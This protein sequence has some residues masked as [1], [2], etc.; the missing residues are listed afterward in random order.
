MEQNQNQCGRNVQEESSN[1]CAGHE[2]LDRSERILAA[3]GELVDFST[4]KLT[5]I[6]TPSEPQATQGS[7]PMAE[8]P[9]YFQEL[10]LNLCGVMSKMNELRDLIERVEV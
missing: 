5:K 7:V 8:L 10:R 6:A 1:P 4:A 2:V 9:P 3:M